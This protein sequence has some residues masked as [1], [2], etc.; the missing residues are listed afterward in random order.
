M[1]WR[2]VAAILAI[3]R[4]QMRQDYCAGTGAEESSRALFFVLV[5]IFHN[6]DAF[7]ASATMLGRR[8]STS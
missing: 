2:S 4:A 6:A 1:S 8:H 3:P 5:F 7:F